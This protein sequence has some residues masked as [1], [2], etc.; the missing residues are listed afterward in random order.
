MGDVVQITNEFE[1]EA[2]TRVIE[3]LRSKAPDGSSVVPT[4]ADPTDPIAPD[5]EDEEDE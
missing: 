2:K 3:L 5:Y 4:F 1:I